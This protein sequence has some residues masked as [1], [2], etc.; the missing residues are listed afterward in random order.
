MVIKSERHG[1]VLTLTRQG[2]NAIA[3][4]LDIRSGDGKVI[5]RMD[6]D[7]YVV[8]RNNILS[9]KKNKS[10]LTV[11]D[12][13]GREVLGIEYLNPNVIRMGGTFFPEQQ[14]VGNS[15]RGTSGPDFVLP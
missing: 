15:G 2:N 4:N 8:N 13:Y 9:I 10:S 11:L 7:G 1:D 12:L 6:R 5:V 14:I 3:V